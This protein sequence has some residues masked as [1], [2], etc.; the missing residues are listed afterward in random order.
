[1]KVVSVLFA[2]LGCLPFGCAW[3]VSPSRAVQRK[4]SVASGAGGAPRTTRNVPV[5]ATALSTGTFTSTTPTLDQLKFQILQL[6][7]A[8]DRGQSYNPTSGEQYRGSMDTARSKIIDLLE[9]YPNNVPTTLEDIQGEWELVLS[10]VKHGIFRSSP[11]FLAVQEAF[12]FAE[13]KST[14]YVYSC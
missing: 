12:S 10:T 3:T 6:G 4:R 7:A 1:M 9:Q 14:S 13:E 11:F 5:M 2:V 8:L